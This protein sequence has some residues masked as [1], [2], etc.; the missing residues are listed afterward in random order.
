MAPGVIVTFVVCVPLILLLNKKSLLGR[1][2]DYDNVLAAAG[3]Y[4]I[5]DWGL[6]WKCTFVLGVV[7]IGFLLHPIHHLELS[8]LFLF[9]F[10]F[11]FLLLVAT[12]VRQA[13]LSFST[14]ITSVSLLGAR[15]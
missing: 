14:A 5:T 1:I 10:R 9:L 8:F 13:F 4:R 11:L 3:D 7:V 12:L 6:F 2:P 15:V